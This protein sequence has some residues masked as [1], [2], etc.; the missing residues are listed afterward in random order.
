VDLPGY[1]YAK[2]AKTA[3]RGFATLIREYLSNRR[4]LIGVVWLLDIRRE[5]S[6][7]DQE[8]KALL[9]ARDL[10]VII[11]V[12]KADKVSRGRWGPRVEAICSS[13][14]AA[15]VACVVTSARTGEGVSELRDALL[16][17]IEHV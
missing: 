10:P 9:A 3:R 4:E 1:G 2:A 13:L 7:E 17:L 14:D 8:A 11:A 16:A 15:D 6:R 12:T 5:P